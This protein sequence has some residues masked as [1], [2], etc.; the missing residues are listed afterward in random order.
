MNAG[1]KV[2][3]AVTP[4]DAQDVEGHR[5]TFGMERGKRTLML[6]TST[7]CGTCAS[8]LP[9][10]RRLARIERDN[11]EIRLVAFGT[12]LESG[13]KYAREH[14]LD[15]TTPVIVSDDLAIQYRVSIA[16]YGLVIDRSGVLRAKGLVNSYHD[17]ESLLNAEEMGVRS[18]DQ[19]IKRQQGIQPN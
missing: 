3:E 4:L 12:D 6:F 5:V 19:F 13:K 14:A 16:P 9:Q 15:S 7:G 10:I 2:G 1:P 18:I 8:L 17:I 11:L